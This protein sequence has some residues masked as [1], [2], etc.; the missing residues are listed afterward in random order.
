MR[1]AR[2]ARGRTATSTGKPKGKGGAAGGAGEGEGGEGEGEGRVL[3]FELPELKDE[4]PIED[5]ARVE[6]VEPEDLIASVHKIR[7]YANTLKKRNELHS[8]AMVKLSNGLRFVHQKWMDA[9]KIIKANTRTMPRGNGQAPELSFVPE[10]KRKQLY[11]YLATTP[12]QD[13]GYAS[14]FRAPAATVPAYLQSFLSKRYAVDENTQAKVLE[15]QAANDLCIVVDAVMAANPESA[16][17]QMPRSQRIKRLK[18]YKDFKG[19]SEELREAAM[20]TATAGEGLEWVPTILS[21]QLRELI[22]AE[23]VLAGYFD[24]SAMPGK[25]WD[26]PVE[27]ADAIAFL[28]A[29]AL[30]DPAAA[31]AKPTASVPG[32]R[33][34]TLTAQKF[35]ARV[36]LS[37]EAE[38]DLII[39]AVP[40]AMMRVAR[41]IA[42]G[43]E[44][45][46]VDG[47]KSGTIDTADVPGTT[48]VRSAW[49]G[50]RKVQKLVGA[51]LEVDL[52]VLSAE[53]LANMKGVLKEYGQAP[54]EGLW[55]GGYSAFVRMLTLYDKTTGGAPFVLF[56]NQLGAPTTFQRG[57]FAQLFGSPFVVSQFVREDLNASGIFDNVTVTK[58]ILLY[59]NRRCFQGGERRAVT[60]RRAN[61]LKMETDQILLMATWRGDFQKVNYAGTQR[62]VALGKNIAS[63]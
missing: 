18:V 14:M 7:D 32:T 37:W 49:D 56:A 19:L 62:F 53:A 45:A 6:V 26:N 2:E 51:T 61:E 35:G 33:K 63:Y 43:R 42:R 17:G 29:E 15:W 20:D 9:E 40:H 8:D 54:D 10:A 22:Y 38:E 39:P 12:P 36:V 4:E 13:L 44:K 21:S 31:A 57:T 30:D 28:V 25:I 60:L 50:L 24:W 46:L 1:P 47:Q 23:L 48:D 55:V 59:T 58:T 3:R 27:G 34:M 11:R 41:A 52:A 5:L 16:Y